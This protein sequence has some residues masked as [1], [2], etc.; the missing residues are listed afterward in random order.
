ML[1]PNARLFTIKGNLFKYE[2]NALHICTDGTWNKYERY[3]TY[4]KAFESAEEIVD[5]Y[6]AMR[7]YL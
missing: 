3:P 2:F 5:E 6:Y 4:V 7:A 1:D